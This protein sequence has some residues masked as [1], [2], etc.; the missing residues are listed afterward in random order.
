MFETFYVSL[1]RRIASRR[2]RSDARS[3]ESDPPGLFQLQIARMSRAMIDR[4]YYNDCRP[5]SRRKR[6]SLQDEVARKWRRNSL[7]RLNQRPEMVWSRL[8]RN[9]NIWYTGARLPCAKLE[10][11]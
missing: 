4:N 1:V 7:K 10:V 9:H 11:T 5:G 2:D 8:P 6:T 3:N